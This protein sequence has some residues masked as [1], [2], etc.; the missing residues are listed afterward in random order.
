MVVMSEGW[1]LAN[2]PTPTFNDVPPGSPFY[3]YVETAVAHGVVSGYPDGTFR[4]GGLTTRGQIAKV[5][6]YANTSQLT[7]Q[8]QQTIDFV[9]QR[10]AAL[11]LVTLHADPALSRAS[12]RHSY[13]IG[14]LGLCQHEGT[15]GSSP[16]DRAAQAGYTGF[17]MG[18][19]VGCGYPTPLS[20]VDG[21]LGRKAHYAILTDANARDIG[22]GWW[23]NASGYGWQTCMTG[24]P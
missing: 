9:N 24:T 10:R 21:W 4:P 20:V 1:P 11:G 16:W 13:D 17:A 23:I 2:P 19:V 22:C 8:E 15:D 14:P 6:Y 3:G 12:R 7:P 18:E 5:V